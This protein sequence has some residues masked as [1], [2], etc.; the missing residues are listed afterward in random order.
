MTDNFILPS[1]W[2]I[3]DE[4]GFLG[5]V[6][7][8]I[9]RWEEDRLVLGFAAQDKH[10]NRRDYVQGGMLVTL[11]DRTMGQTLREKIGEKPVATIHLDVH[12]ISAAHIGEFIEARAKIVRITSNVVFLEAKLTVDSRLVLTAKGIWKRLKE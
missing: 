8:I 2:F 11:A 9:Q 3:H 10:R 1:G 12:F 4:N 6:G 7:P 5:H